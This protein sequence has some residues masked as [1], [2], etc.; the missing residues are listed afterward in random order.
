MPLKFQRYAIFYWLNSGSLDDIYVEKKIKFVLEGGAIGAK[1]KLNLRAT[2][3]G[4]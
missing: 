3:V 1:R 4:G 2:G